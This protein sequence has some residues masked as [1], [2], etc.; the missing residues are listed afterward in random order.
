MNFVLMFFACEQTEVVLVA[1]FGAGS[2]LNMPLW[3]VAE[4]AVVGALIG[5]I[6]IRIG[7]EGPE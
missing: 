3:F 4:G 5:G 2:P 7:G 6:A 1:M